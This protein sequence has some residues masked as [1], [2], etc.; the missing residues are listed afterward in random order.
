MVR[1]DGEEVVACAL[2]LEC[3]SGVIVSGTRWNGSLLVI[4]PV[5][6]LAVPFRFHQFVFSSLVFM[7]FVV[8]V[9]APFVLV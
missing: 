9:Y 7:S 6:P 3:S 4:P 8:Q 2:L 5:L 1:G